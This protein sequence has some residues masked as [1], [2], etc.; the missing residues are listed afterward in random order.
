MTMPPMLAPLPRPGEALQRLKM[1]YR[2]FTDQHGRKFGALA[3]IGN[4]RP[5]EELRPI[6]CM[7]PWLPLMR[8][9]RWDEDHQL[10]FRWDY[11]TIAAELS[12]YT[13]TW[14]GNAQKMALKEH[15]PIPEVGGEV[16]P[17][18]KNVFGNPGLSPEIPLAAELGHPWILYGDD[19]SPRDAHLFGLLNQGLTMQSNEALDIIER[20]LRDRMGIG[21]NAPTQPEVPQQVIDSANA[22][23][24]K[25]GAP[26]TIKGIGPQDGV[27]AEIDRMGK[28]LEARIRSE[29]GTTAQPIAAVPVAEK[30]VKPIKYSA[31]FAECRSRGMPVPEIAAAWRE[32]KESLKRAS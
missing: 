19:F 6:G 5:I 16:D 25:P 1:V 29:L 10:T 7:P 2:I 8:F 30:P 27:Q 3:D 24:Q 21:N 17:L 13:A 31:F 9:I 12:A 32:H 14:Y 23:M 22:A 18:I 11:R 4:N 26:K 20:R 15:L 28:E